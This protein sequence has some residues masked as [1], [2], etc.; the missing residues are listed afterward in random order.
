MRVSSRLVA[1]ICGRKGLLALRRLRGVFGAASCF[2]VLHCEF[3]F[4]SGLLAR[5]LRAATDTKFGE[6]GRGQ[7]LDRIGLL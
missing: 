4:G 3:G 1:E 5:L 2:L 6:E 7:L